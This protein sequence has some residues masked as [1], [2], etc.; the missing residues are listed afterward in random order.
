MN[1][2]KC[3]EIDNVDGTYK[4][5]MKSQME[6]QLKTQKKKGKEKC[7]TDMTNKENKTNE[8][9]S[10]GDIFGKETMTKSDFKKGKARKAGASKGNGHESNKKSSSKINKPSKKKSSV[11][12]DKAN[13]ITAAT[14]ERLS[15]K[16][17]KKGNKSKE[18]NDKISQSFVVKAV[19][20]D[21]QLKN[22]TS[23]EESKE[24]IKNF[25]KSDKNL[26]GLT[27][28]KRSKKLKKKTLGKEK[29]K[30]RTKKSEM[31][32]IIKF[33]EHGK[34][35]VNH[36]PKGTLGS[37]KRK[38]S[39]N[40]WIS[41]EGSMV[42]LSEQ[43]NSWSLADHLGITDN[44]DYQFENE[45]KKQK[46]SFEAG[47][48]FI[49][50]DKILDESENERINKSNEVNNGSAPIR[51]AWETRESVLTKLE[52]KNTAQKNSKTEN[53]DFVP[54]EKSEKEKSKGDSY[55]EA[56]SK[57][58]SKKTEK[59]H[60][61]KSSTVSRMDNI[62]HTSLKIENEKAAA[63]SSK[64]DHHDVVPLEKIEKIVSMKNLQKQS[65][66]DRE[67]AK[68]NLNTSSISR[69]ARA[70]ENM[71]NVPLSFEKN[72]AGT[73]IFFTENC[74]FDSLGKNEK[75]ENSEKRNQRKAS[76]V[77]VQK[78]IAIK[79]KKSRRQE[80]DLDCKLH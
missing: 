8:K 22:D 15:K 59:V 72:K 33:G 43:N 38:I 53:C 60:V 80:D 68:R 13:E 48:E 3:Q 78:E 50:V 40:P 35:E 45:K 36:K 11:L 74:D 32:S 28:F 39:L 23:V 52:T 79:Q 44:S 20:L 18:S 61:I 30:I 9:S 21:N 19:V 71:E 2:D 34:Q 6:Y 58:E 69:N 70:M 41:E 47:E 12:I 24:R 73:K 7:S 63:K 56:G 55:D 31:N 57:T 46:R 5:Q 64:T 54:T 75:V 42:A 77:V 37:R 66:S 10:S 27:D 62:S 16:K 76:R 29:V 14:S 1:Y 17:K 49:V 26:V 4:E 51:T 25:R 67:S 65:G